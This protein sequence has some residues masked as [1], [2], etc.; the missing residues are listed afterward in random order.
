[1]NMSTNPKGG[2]LCSPHQR[3]HIRTTMQRMELDTLRVTLFH[4][5]FWTGAGLPEPPLGMDLDAFLCSLTKAQASAV[6]KALL[7]EVD[8]E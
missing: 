2:S 6:I 3:L 4:R 8:D 7:A 1:M 5:R